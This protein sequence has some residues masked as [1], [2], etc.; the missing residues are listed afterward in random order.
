MQS[1]S[2]SRGTASHTVGGDSR[3]VETPASPIG[4]RPLRRESGA[5]QSSSTHRIEVAGGRTLVA[6]VRHGEGT[7]VVFLHGLFS[8][9]ETWTRVS[10]EL[11]RTSIAF[12]LPGFGQSDPSGR[13]VAAKAEDVAAA[14]RAL[15]LERFELV[16]HSFGGAV[17]ARVAEL[18]PE[19]VVSLVLLAPAGF[20]RLATAVHRRARAYRGPVTAVLG[21]RDRIVRTSHGRGVTRA[22]PAAQVVLFDGVGHHLQADRREAVVEL[23][24]TGRVTAGSRVLA[25]RR[26]RFVAAPL[27]AQPRFA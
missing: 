2:K 14:I 11:D 8:S 26:R 9:S 10:A 20:G 25:N 5:M 6:R 23:I 15:G 7:P 21:T 12:D 4:A 27:T 1:S 18:M 17:A 19:Q 3:T 22:F 13:G 24:A 16:G